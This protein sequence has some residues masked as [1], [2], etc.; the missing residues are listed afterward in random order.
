MRIFFP[1]IALQCSRR[2]LDAAFRKGGKKSEPNASSCGECFHN[3]LCSIFLKSLALFPPN[4]MNLFIYLKTKKIC[5]CSQLNVQSSSHSIQSRV[6][7]IACK[8]VIL[9]AQLSRWKP[10]LSLDSFPTFPLRKPLRKVDTIHSPPT[11]S[12]S[13][14]LIILTHFSSTNLSSTANCSSSLHDKAP[15]ITNWFSCFWP[16]VLLL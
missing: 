4:E 7:E 1:I 9:G 5:L 12:V 14:T 11:G 3:K 13:S 8:T 16:V 10:N 2:R 6:V 15:K